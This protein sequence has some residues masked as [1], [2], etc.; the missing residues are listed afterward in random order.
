VTS[1]GSAEEAANCQASIEQAVALPQRDDLP[2]R[3]VLADEH[4]GVSTPFPDRVAALGL[5]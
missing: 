1:Q 2:F 3:W 5:R 4:F